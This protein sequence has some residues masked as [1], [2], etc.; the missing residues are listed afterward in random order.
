[1]AESLRTLV[2]R[3]PLMR[4]LVKTAVAVVIIMALAV[5]ILP[6][7]TRFPDMEEGARDA[8]W[9]SIDTA[10]L[11]M[12]A[13]NAIE[14]VVAHDE[15][16]SSSATNTWSAL[17]AGPGTR[18]LDDYLQS[19]TSVYFYC[20]DEQARITQQFVTAEACS[21]QRDTGPFANL[22]QGP[23]PELDRPFHVKV[24]QSALI[25]SEALEIRFEAVVGDSRCI[26]VVECYWPEAKAKVLLSA[27]DTNSGE[28]LGLELVL[29]EGNHDLGTRTFGGHSVTLVE[30]LPHPTGQTIDASEYTAVLLVSDAL[31][32]SLVTRLWPF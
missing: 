24:N 30:L 7:I 26:P 21:N 1:M 9:A 23:A 19:V 27:V 8:E 28:E 18:P 12:L 13:D 4:V 32:E 29:W 14:T 15:S 20:Y 6:N 31:D 22:D 25:E 11:A 16:T 3:V 10:M 17:P 5:L 2:K